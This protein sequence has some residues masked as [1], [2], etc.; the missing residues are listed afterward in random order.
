MSWHTHPRTDR[1]LSD[2]LLSRSPDP[3]VRSSRPFLAPGSRRRRQRGGRHVRGQRTRAAQL[4]SDP[5]PS[6]HAR[7][8]L[9]PATPGAPRAERRRPLREKEIRTCGKPSVACRGHAGGR[10]G[11]CRLAVRTHG[12]MALLRPWLSC[13]HPTRAGGGHRSKTG[14]MSAIPQRTPEREPRPS[15]PSQEPQLS[16]AGGRGWR[17]QRARHRQRASRRR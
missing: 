4:P 5:W 2:P 14:R 10:K 1:P 11:P 7:P 3:A 6:A 15:M 9:P 13:R 8:P 16:S 12:A 17:C